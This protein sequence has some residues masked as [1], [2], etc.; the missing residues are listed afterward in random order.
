MRTQQKKS[1]PSHSIIKEM[2][3]PIIDYSSL[4]YK[5]AN[6]PLPISLW[7]PKRF[8]YNIID[9]FIWMLGI[10]VFVIFIL[11]VFC[12]TDVIIPTSTLFAW[13]LLF[14]AIAILCT[15]LQYYNDKILLLEEEVVFQKQK[16]KLRKKK[17]V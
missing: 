4:K 3:R 14:V 13:A 11:S 8:F 15:L 9:M 5:L 1:K 6:T 12:G 7:S 17:N 2:H 16:N 10:F